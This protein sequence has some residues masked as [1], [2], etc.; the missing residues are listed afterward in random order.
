MIVM[1][2][3]LN[4][5]FN[6]LSILLPVQLIFFS[7]FSH[8]LLSFSNSLSLSHT[9]ILFPS[10][11][12]VLLNTPLPWLSGHLSSVPGHLP[13]VPGHLT[14]S[15]WSSFTY[16]SINLRSSPITFKSASMTLRSSSMALRLPSMALRL[17]SVAFISHRSSSISPW[18]S[19]IRPSIS[20]RCSPNTFR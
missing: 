10:L 2:S 11:A 3:S 4:L 9:I 7:T 20:L 15:H 1:I 8:L 6:A 13:S 17:S 5:F 18:P 19:F 14:I 16:P 12:L